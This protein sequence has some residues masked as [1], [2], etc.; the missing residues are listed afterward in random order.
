MLQLRLTASVRLILVSLALLFVFIVTA[1]RAEAQGP[2]GDHSIFIPLLI[3]T[4][5]PPLP[6]VQGAFFVQADVKTGSAA[7]AVDKQGGMH[8]TYDYYV[9][10]FPNPGEDPSDHPAAVYL[11]CANQGSN[12]CANPANWK[13]VAMA[14]RV[15]EVQLALTPAGQPRLLIRLATT[16]GSSEND[17]YY[18]ACDQTCSLSTHWTLTYLGTTKPPSVLFD[19]TTPQRSFALDTKGRP[20]F[21]YLDD[22]LGHRGTYY[23][24]CDENCTDGNFWFE[25]KLD[26]GIDPLREFFYYPSLSFTTQDQPRVVADGG[27]LLQGPTGI[28]YLACDVNCEDHDNWE[29]VYLFERGFEENVSWDLEI[30]GSQPRLAFYEGSQ[31]NG[32]GNILY[33][34]WC[35]NNC[36]NAAG[37]QRRNLGLGSLNGKHPDLELDGQD[38]PRLAYLLQDG[39]GVGYAWCSGNCESAQGQW[40]QRV[41][42][43]STKLEKEYPV[44][45][46]VI[47]DAGLWDGIAPTLALDPAGNP[48]LA[49]DAAY[50]T[51][52]LYD[53]DPDDNIPPIRDFWQLWHSVRVTYFPQ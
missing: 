44:A 17:Y 38:R 25:T 49:Y 3:R 51:R 10:E 21:V 32:G 30:A 14:D 34:A 16:S 35:N 31:L 9:P 26:R 11:Y 50:H 18:A 41:V 13:G 48:R 37:W 27:H 2:Q 52:C 19:L 4:G 23:A 33:Y 6:P 15:N 24:Y 40:Q 46:P 43:T 47:C 20:R 39:G 45:R 42:D 8:L 53:N 5:A 1:R 36:L 12:Q 7:I 29:R 22:N 28:Y